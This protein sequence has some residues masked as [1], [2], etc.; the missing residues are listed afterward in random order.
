MAVDEYRDSRRRIRESITQPA[1]AR[2]KQKPTT[3]ELRRCIYCGSPALNVVC[4]GHLDLLGT[5]EAER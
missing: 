1:A 4:A 2:G 5:L 3:V